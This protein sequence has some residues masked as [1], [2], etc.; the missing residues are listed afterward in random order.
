MNVSGWMGGIL[1]YGVAGIAIEGLG[2]PWTLLASAL[3][4]LVAVGL[5]VPIRMATG[6]ARVSGPPSAVAGGGK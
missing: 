6:D 3:S 4:G 5:L 1:G 2:I